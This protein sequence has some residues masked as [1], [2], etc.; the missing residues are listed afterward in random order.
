MKARV[1]SIAVVQRDVKLRYVDQVLYPILRAV[2]V[3]GGV[4]MVAERS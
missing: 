1:V 4:M 3:K 2:N